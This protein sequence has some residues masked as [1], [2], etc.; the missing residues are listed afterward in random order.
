MRHLLCW[1]GRSWQTETPG[2]RLPCGSQTG[3]YALLGDGFTFER[4]DAGASGSKSRAPHRNPP[5]S[6]SLRPQKK[7]SGRNVELLSQALNLF[8]REIA[9]AV[10]RV[11]DGSFGAENVD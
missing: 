7:N 10:E 2:R 6:G 11:G 9:F 8:G 1:D 3:G 4:P 5:Q